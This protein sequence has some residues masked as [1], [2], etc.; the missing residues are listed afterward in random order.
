MADSIMNNPFLNLLK[1][2]NL[3]KIKIDKELI[4]VFKIVIA[5]MSD[6]FL[7]NNL[8]DA[9]DWNSIFQT[10][11]LTKNDSQYTIKYGNFEDMEWCGGKYVKK[12][13]KILIKENRPETLY[14]TLC[15]EFIHFLV[16]VDSNSLNWKL[17]DACILNEGLTQLLTIDILNIKDNL[18]YIEEVQLA[19]IYCELSKDKEPIKQFLCD[20]YTFE[21]ESDIQNIGIR[22]RYYENNHDKYSYGDV[23]KYVI[24]NSIDINSID[25]ISSYISLVN[26]LR[27]RRNPDFEYIDSL[28]DAITDNLVSKMESDE[29]S[30]KYLKT[31]LINFQKSADYS[32][33]CGNNEVAIYLMNDL[34]IAFDQKGNH[35]VDFPSDGEHARGQTMT[36]MY[37]NRIEVIHRDKKYVID[38]TKMKCRNWQTI[39]DSY[40]EEII[41]EINEDN[42]IN[43]VK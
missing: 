21:D 2:E 20:K 18:T 28:F 11:L 41:K 9:K 12:D 19:E 8:I 29:D 31:K 23:Q 24:R 25:S 17:S 1:E 5:K 16:M 30:K 36:D 33:M 34:R 38:T 37:H 32:Q 43:K 22:S 27:K 40:L 6:Y 35:Y 3:N 42:K 14:E 10:Y 4:S 15:H 26:I 39:Y 13:F 7:Q